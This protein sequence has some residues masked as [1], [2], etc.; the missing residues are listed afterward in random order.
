[1]NED[2]TWFCPGTYKI[3]SEQNVTVA[4]QRKTVVP[5][6]VH[7]NGLGRVHIN[8]KHPSAKHILLAVGSAMDRGQLLEKRTYS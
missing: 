1:M 8:Y 2:F 5:L 3:L 7:H 4:Q 6:I